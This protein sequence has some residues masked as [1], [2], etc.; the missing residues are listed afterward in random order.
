MSEKP[1]EIAFVVYDGLTPLDLVGPLQVFSALEMFAP[2]YRPVV[3]GESLEPVA[4]DCPFSIVPQKTY[5]EVPD[6]FMV[7]VPGGT[8]PTLRALCDQPRP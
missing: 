6:P 4:T 8:A 7:V 3:V 1:H 5:S 2:Q